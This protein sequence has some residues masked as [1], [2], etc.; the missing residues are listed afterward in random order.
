MRNADMHS[1]DL[2]VSMWTRDHEARW[3]QSH[4]CQ[5]SVSL[6]SV[7]NGRISRANEIDCSQTLETSL[8]IVPAAHEGFVPG[9]RHVPPGLLASL[10]GEPTHRG[11]ERGVPGSSLRWGGRTA[12]VPCCE[13]PPVGWRHWGAGTQELFPSN[14][15][16]PLLLCQQEHSDAPWP[17]APLLP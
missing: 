12:V 3:C 1:G 16:A 17:P 7:T 13:H 8:R 6:Q 11:V 5:Q 15:G 4:I 10:Q 14:Q 2:L 9:A